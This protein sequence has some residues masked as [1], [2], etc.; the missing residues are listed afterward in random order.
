VKG[1]SYEGVQGGFKV[2][3]QGVLDGRES[4]S[5]MNV[6]VEET[7]QIR[8]QILLE[9]RCESEAKSMWYREKG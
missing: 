3:G 6:R 4:F 9:V 5:G 7:G 1:T 2:G 8:G